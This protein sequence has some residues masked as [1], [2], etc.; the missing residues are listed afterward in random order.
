MQR[1]LKHGG[2]K[3]LF[4][5]I[6]IISLAR[7]GTATTV[8]VP[9]DDDLI[10]GARA[11]VRGKVLSMASTYEPEQNK[12][13][14]YVKLKV[15]EVLKGQVTERKIVIKLLGGQS[16]EYSTTIF[17]NPEFKVGEKTVVYLD[18]WPDGSLKVHHLFLGKYTISRDGITGREIATRTVTD[19][20]IIKLQIQGKDGQPSKTITERME[21]SS[22]VA[23]IRSRLSANWDRSVAF[24]QR[25]YSGLPMRAV[26][27]EYGS[28]VKDGKITPQFTF[29]TNPPRRWFEPDTG[30]P[31]VAKVKLAGAPGASTLQDVEAAMGAWTGVPGCALQVQSGGTMTNCYTGL[32]GIGVVFDNCDGYNSASPTCSGTLAWGGFSQ[33]SSSTRVVNGVT[34]ARVTQGFVSFNPWA[35]CFFTIPCNVREVATHE[36][37]HALGLGH[38][39]DGNATMAPTAHFNGRCASIFSDDQAGIRFIYPA[40]GGPL[41]ITTTTLAGAT[42][43]SAYSGQV[44]AI[45]GT[46]PYTWQVT[47]GSLPPGLSIASTSATTAGITGTPTTD[48]NYNFTVQATDNAGATATKALTISVGQASTQYNSQLVSQTVPATAL[49]GQ[50]FNSNFKW[51]NTGTQPWNGLGGF[52]LVSQN[53]ANNTT[54]GGDQVVPTTLFINPGETLDITFT[55]F[56]PAAPGTYNFQWQTFQTGVNFFGQPSNNVAISVGGGNPTNNA[57]FVSQSVPT[58]MTA[59]QSVSVSVTMRN[60]GST[61]WEAGTYKLGSQNPSGN[62]TWGFSQVN[63]TSAVAPGAQK[64]FTFNVTAPPG[65]GS[66][67]FQWRMLED[68]TG[69][70]GATSTNVSVNV[71]GGAGGGTDDASFVSQS[72]PTSMNSGD[73]V[74]VSVRMRNSGTNTWTAGTYKLGSQNPGDNMNWGMNR[75]S[76]PSS[77]APGGSAIF[78]FDVTAPSSGGPFNFQWRMFKEGMGFFGGMSTNVPINVNGPPPV[79]TIRPTT[80][81][82]FRP[83]NG[84]L[85]LKNSNSTGF[86]DLLLTYGV[87]GDIA[88]AGDWNGD[89]IDTIGVYRNGDFLLRNSNT[90]GFADI[91]VSFGMP[92]DQPIVGD[93]DGNG[94]TTIGIYRNGTFMLRNSNTPGDPEIVFSLGNPGDV[95]ISGDWDGNGTVTTGVFRP[96]NGALFLKNTNATGFA[97]I[98]LTYGLPGDKPVT[99]DWNGDGVDTIGVYRDGTFMLRNSNTNGFAEIVFALGVPGDM[100]IAGDWDGLQ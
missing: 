2:L 69:W 48:G 85:F 31:V 45:G 87:P 23:M 27:E 11:I 56:A 89:G 75:V 67:N 78:T 65:A 20:N 44:T 72:V 62:T 49:P 55:A 91:V 61:N 32:A 83:S 70:F 86:A 22:F 100:P 43:G 14:T 66:Y 10:V 99:G 16:G 36:I 58:T 77:V 1:V 52:K 34:F 93:W 82:V 4:L 76:L 3:L 33:I 64:T 59:G 30:L 41:T 42:T 47:A 74:R 79:P 63:L 98:M 50:S 29:I 28:K 13:Y 68:A 81:G 71:T 18:T 54:W 6:A 97:D 8:I 9:S 88:V 73:V 92:G 80:T 90:N 19:T 5:F 95:P 53:P 40:T 24:D 7:T 35:S 57:E 94:T 96:A 26:P 51:L 25:Y 17:G 15:Q 12:V 21:L 37:G 39:A 38:S 84:S 60:T 46:S